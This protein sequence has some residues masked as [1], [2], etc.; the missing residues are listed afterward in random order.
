MKKNKVMQ[1]CSGLAAVQVGHDQNDPRNPSVR[2]ACPA[3]IVNKLTV[4]NAGTS[5]AEAHAARLRTYRFIITSGDGQRAQH[6]LLFSGKRISV[7]LSK[8]SVVA[9]SVQR[10]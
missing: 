9:G 1:R 3:K 4:P 10:A 7:V 6:K 8:N 5:Y 2:V